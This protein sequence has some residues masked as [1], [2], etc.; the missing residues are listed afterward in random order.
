MSKIDHSLFSANEHAL[1][2]AYGSCPVC[3]AKLQIKRSQ[4]GPFLGCSEYPTCSFSK[5]LKD[6]ETKELKLIDGSSCPECSSQL[7][8]KKGRYG[9]F[10]GCSNFPQCHH[11]ETM[12]QTD[13][14]KVVCPSCKTGHLLKRTNKFGKSFYACSRFP[15]CKYALNQQP[16]EHTCPKCQWP[17]MLQKNMASGLVYQCPQKHCA[18]KVTPE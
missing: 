14:T 13:D 9:L 4:S 8:I 16:V 15:T 6:T 17:V 18:H 12:H 2:N 10:I 1:E 3:Q 7:A 11:I 5:P